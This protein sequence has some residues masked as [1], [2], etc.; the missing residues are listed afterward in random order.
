MEQRQNKHSITVEFLIWQDTR[1]AQ[2]LKVLGAYSDRNF[3]PGVIHD[4]KPVPLCLNIWI[5]GLW[6]CLR[7]RNDK[8]FRCWLCKC[9]LQW[10]KKPFFILF[11]WND[12]PRHL[13]RLTCQLPSR[14]THFAVVTQNRKNTKH[15]TG[16]IY[17]WRRVEPLEL[18]SGREKWRKPFQHHNPST[19]CEA[20]TQVREVSQVCRSPVLNRWWGERVM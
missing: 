6:V 7:H 2:E 11:H 13:W 15:Q 4:V 18:L 20:S 10:L 5:M 8:L 3:L 17:D 14:E 9:F 16:S 1:G 12:W 19:A